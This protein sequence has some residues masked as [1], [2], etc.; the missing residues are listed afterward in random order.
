MVK[1]LVFDTETTGLPPITSTLYNERNMINK[2]LICSNYE[3]S[4]FFWNKWI[5]KWAYITQL[6][7]ILYDTEN[8]ANVKIFNKYIDLLPNVE[9][10]PESS[11][12]TNIYKNENEVLN[13][14]IDIHNKE[15][16]ILSNMK[17]KNMLILIENALNE[18]MIDFNKSDYVVAHNVEFDKKMILSEL[19][20]LNKISDIKNI[21]TTKKFVCTLLL[22]KDICKIEMI[23]KNNVKYIKFPKLCES[24]ECMFGYK[25]TSLHNAI[26]DVVICLRIYCKLYNINVFG[27]NIE[28][29]Q[30]INDISPK[31]FQYKYHINL[32]K[33]KNIKNVKNVK[34][35]K[36]VKN[37]FVPTRMVTR[38]QTKQLNN[39]IQLLC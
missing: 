23:S 14:G 9:I 8:P 1:I 28:I 10:S 27:I 16:F 15:L 21:L 12:I 36:N 18:F 4:S 25:P 24:Y 26:Y 7:Y 33:V 30:L 32:K 5:D 37:V 31:L 38:S 19:F 3:V 29:T 34:N 17:K 39:Q 35:I 6:S 2:I 20:R 11:K 13:A 22:T